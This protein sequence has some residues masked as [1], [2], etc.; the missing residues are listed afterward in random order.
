MAASGGYYLLAAG[1]LEIL[2]SRLISI[3]GEKLFG[4]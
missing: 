1:N 4:W 3:R 2:N